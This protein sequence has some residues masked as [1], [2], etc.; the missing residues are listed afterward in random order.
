MSASRR[1]RT[2]RP[3]S[4]KNRQFGRSEK[5]RLGANSHSLPSRNSTQQSIEIVRRTIAAPSDV[6]IRA[7]QCKVC[8]VE[9]A[10]NRRRG[11]D[12]LQRQPSCL[13]ESGNPVGRSRLRQTQERKA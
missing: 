9:F 4:A 13:G 3:L 11:L 5:C 1:K 10:S 8:V 6:L 7:D 2:S 12:Y